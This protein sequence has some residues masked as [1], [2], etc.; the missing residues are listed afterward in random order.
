M[1]AYLV[2]I[3]T[4]DLDIAISQCGNTG[5]ESIISVKLLEILQ[6]VHRALFL[7]WKP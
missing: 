3:Q 6:I 5:A 7:Q 2:F 4:R 1:P